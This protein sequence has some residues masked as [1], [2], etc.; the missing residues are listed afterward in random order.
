ME[1]DGINNDVQWYDTITIEQVRDEFTAAGAKVVWAKLMGRNNNSKQ[2][3]WL[4]GDPSDLSFLPL[5]VPSYNEGTSRKKKAGPLVVRIPVSWNWIVP[6]VGR[7]LAPDAKLCYYPQYPEV[8][9]SGFLRG[10]SMAPNELM[11]PSKRGFEEGRVLFFATVDIDGEHP[12]VVAMVVGAPSPA[13]AYMYALGADAAGKPKP[14]V[15]PGMQVL[16]EISVL[17]NALKG[18]VGEKIVPCRLLGDGTVIRP[19]IA[20]NAAGFT[21]EAEMGV[22]ENS[23]PGPDFDVWELKAIKQVNLLKRHNHKVTLFTP[24]PDRGWITEHPQTD[25]V[26]RYGHVYKTNEQG[27]PVSYYFTSGDFEGIGTDKP[28]ARLRMQIE[29]FR[30]SKDFDPSGMIELVDKETG[31]VAAGWSFMKLLDHWQRK[32]NRAAYVPY[33]KEGDG[34][35]TLLEFGPLIT[36]GISTSFGLFLQAFS[37]GKVV[38]DPGDK[39]VLRDGKWVP[40][41]RSQFRINL[42][43]IGAIYQE[44]RFIDIRD[45]AD[46]GQR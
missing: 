33:A 45:D 15:S 30:N 16:D 27:K 24:Q 8:R 32:H 31:E 44:T 10:C 25:F 14:V 5:G 12:T 39:A 35:S 6:G 46:D 40:H 4:A 2:Q 26:L 9:F 43:D 1:H 22:G 23:V 28:S 20:Q 18:F 11:S 17:E 41:S 34:E 38:F 7:F 36:L 42:F 29:G 3:V 21:L 19:Y 37:E 13:A